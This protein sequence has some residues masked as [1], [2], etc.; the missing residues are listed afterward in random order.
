MCA[1][2]NAHNYMSHMSD[3][4]TQT[5]KAN[6][7]TTNSSGTSRTLM[8]IDARNGC[9]R[10]RRYSTLHQISRDRR[11]RVRTTAF[12]LCVCVVPCASRVFAA[13]AREGL[14]T[15]DAMHFHTDIGC[16]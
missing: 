12:C 10:R 11:R 9:G 1:Q 13:A 3:T 15:C 7:H 5:Y 16:I 2:Q 6:M 4:D 14:S 8:K